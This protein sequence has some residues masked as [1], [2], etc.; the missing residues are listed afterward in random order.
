MRLH[1]DVHVVY[2]VHLNPQI[3]EPV[4][5]RLAGDR[6]ITLL[7]PLDYQPLV[8]LMK[9]S[10]LVITDSG[11]IQEEA[12][13]LGK[14][15]LVLR[16]TTERPEGVRAGTV[17]LVGTQPESIV[18]AVELLMSDQEAYRSMAASTNPYGDGNA[19]ER[20]VDHMVRCC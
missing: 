7:Q 14:P 4:Y 6:R 9:Q 17:R 8:W 3:A 10:H 13:G 5:A 12:P 11:G 16:N 20:I 2:P 15:V 19:A 18:D 1:D